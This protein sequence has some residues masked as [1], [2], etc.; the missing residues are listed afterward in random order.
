MRVFTEEEINTMRAIIAPLSDWYRLHARL[1]PWRRSADPYRVWISEI[2]LQQT[3]IAAVLNYY[4]RFTAELP[5]LASLADA[6]EDR[7][8]KLWQGLGYYNRARNL[9]KAARVL[10]TDYGG[11]FPPDYDAIRALPGIGDY[12]AGAIASICF[13][14]PVP[15]I[16]GNVLRI[17]TRLLGA[18]DDIAEE[19]TKKAYRLLLL[20]LM[21]GPASGTFNQALM[22]L[23]Q[24]ICLPNGAPLCGEC[25]L[26][27][28]CA[29]RIHGL[30]DT[31]P[32][33]KRPKAR[34]REVRTV[35]LIFSGTRVALRRR[36]ANGLL[37][38]LWE[39]PNT[40]ASEN[41]DVFPWPE[42]PLFAAPR[43]V[44]RGVHI[45]S[46][47]EWHM[48]AMQCESCSDTLP[49]DWVWADAAALKERYAV[50]N[51][52]QFTEAF[53]RERLNAPA[54]SQPSE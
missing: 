16:D 20:P 11:R 22:E 44:C 37:A 51:A 42:L 40:P 12:T 41:A 29:A 9:Q 26:A 48:T 38:G 49:K 32:V 6:E 46:H 30:T 2:M 19:S 33:K 25:P 31:L 43:E 47:I 39:Y 21:P 1:L 17:L 50:P 54:A 28:L 34:R 14:L 18:P 10:M 5:D 27:S 3:R 45:F 4:T 8:L 24:L 35:W 52:F 53:L 7:L 13:G 36:P 23:G 15:A